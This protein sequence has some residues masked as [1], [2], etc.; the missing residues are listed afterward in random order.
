M[1]SITPKKAGEIKYF[2]QPNKLNTPNAPAFLPRAVR[3]GTANQERILDFI[4]QEGTT[5]T[6]AEGMA[7]FNGLMKALDHFL[8]LGYHVR[9]P[10]AEFRP[11]VQGRIEG[12]D[13]AA[14]G[15]SLSPAVRIIPGVALRNVLKGVSLVSV[16]QRPEVVKVLTFLNTRD[17]SVTALK[18]G[19]LCIVRGQGMTFDPAEAADG[20]FFV[21]VSDKSEHRATEYAHTGNRSVT[22]KAPAELTAGNYSL[23]VRTG[24]NRV[25]PLSGS[26]DATLA[27]N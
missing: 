27:V 4:T 17:Q 20:V 25:R 26:L 13:V 16:E 10:F 24:A 15:N 11:T 9:L 1:S 18:A 19:D 8:S 7:V 12:A 14:N 21:S 2:A 5:I 6:R 23:V 22:F 3:A